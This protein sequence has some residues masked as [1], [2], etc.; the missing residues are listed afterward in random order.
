M[1]RWPKTDLVGWEM[2]KKVTTSRMMLRSVVRSQS[3]RVVVCVCMR[4]PKRDECSGA[5]HWP[6]GC[7]SLTG[8]GLFEYVGTMRV[9]GRRAC[10][11][12]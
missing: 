3:G 5:P 12:G 2:Y 1:A 4:P 7:D 10:R 6:M 11:G 9:K 8:Q